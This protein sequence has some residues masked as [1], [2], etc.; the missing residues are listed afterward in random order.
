L[1]LTETQDQI[2]VH[3][4]PIYSNKVFCLQFFIFTAY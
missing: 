1:V 2:Q 4:W 3:N